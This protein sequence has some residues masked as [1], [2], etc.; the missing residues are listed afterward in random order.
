METILVLIFTL[1][2]HDDG[3][4]DDGNDHDNDDHN[5]ANDDG[6]D[7]NGDGDGDGDAAN[8]WPS[9]FSRLPFDLLMEG[10]CCWRC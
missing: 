2:P 6:Y 1:W 5:E 8:L 3:E 10:L 7:A 9:W 4:Y